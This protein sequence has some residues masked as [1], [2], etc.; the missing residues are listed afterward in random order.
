MKV[1]MHLCSHLDR[2]YTYIGAKMYRTVLRK[3]INARF[4]SN[5]LFS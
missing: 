2:K 3:N 4:V 5:T 1:D